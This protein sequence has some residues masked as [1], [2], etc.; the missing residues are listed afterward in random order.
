MCTHSRLCTPVCTP[1]RCV[2]ARGSRLQRRTGSFPGGCEEEEDEG[3]KRA[4][5]GP[6]VRPPSVLTMDAGL[7]CHGS[8]FGSLVPPERSAWSWPG[9]N[10]LAWTQSSGGCGGSAELRAASRA[11][12]QDP[13]PPPARSAPGGRGRQRRALVA[14]V[15]RAGTG[16]RMADS[17]QLPPRRHGGGLRAP[18]APVEAYRSSGVRSMWRLEPYAEKGAVG[19]REFW[20]EYGRGTDVL[21]RD[22]RWQDT[23]TQK[24]LKVK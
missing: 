20:M 3:T 21:H 4:A 14:R 17:T 10:R 24:S 16:F 19:G 22:T 23:Q 2:H 11:V 7:V 1:P 15:R 6:L 18:E 9:S 12:P 13:D 8:A 5:L